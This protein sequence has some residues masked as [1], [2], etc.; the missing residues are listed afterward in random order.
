MSP[1]TSPQHPGSEAFWEKCLPMLRKWHVSR[2]KDP[3]AVVIEPGGCCGLS[4]LYPDHLH[5]LNTTMCSI[6]NKTRRF[7]MATVSECGTASV[8]SRDREKYHKE[9]LLMNMFRD[10]FIP[11]VLVA[12]STGLGFYFRS[13]SRLCSVRMS[14]VSRLQTRLRGQRLG[15]HTWLWWKWNSWV[16]SQKTINALQE[17]V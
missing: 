14:F 10:F 6:V 11:L 12:D 4:P 13:P 2:G 3:S 16:H 5:D 15:I 7:A 8:P 1:K 17:T 9:T